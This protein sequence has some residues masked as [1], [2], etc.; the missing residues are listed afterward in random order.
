MKG[1]SNSERITKIARKKKEITNWKSKGV[2]NRTFGDV[3]TQLEGFT[4]ES[5]SDTKND[6]IFFY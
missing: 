6:L 5:E 1:E 3:V 4:S 2:K